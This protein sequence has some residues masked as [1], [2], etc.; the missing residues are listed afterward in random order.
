MM[1]IHAFLKVD[2][3]K[4]QD[5][6]AFTQSVVSSSREEEGNISYQLFADP[7]IDN[8]FVFLEMWKDEK[9]I[10]THEK[11]EHFKSFV[12]GLEQF[13]LEPLR[14]EKYQAAGK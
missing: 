5:F 8:E 1:I 14:V 9:A 7:S 12:Q 2:P 4:R 3:N 13:L 10:E 11:T 6:L